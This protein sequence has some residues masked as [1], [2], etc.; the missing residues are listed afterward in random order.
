MIKLKSGVKVSGLKSELLVGM[1]IVASA[2]AEY[3]I[4]CVITSG[5]DST[6]KEHSDH[7]KGYAVDFRVNN[8]PTI[9]IREA[10]EKKVKEAL[11]DDYVFLFETNHFHL[12]YKPIK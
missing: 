6:H 7:Y 8:I 10:I 4:D 3:D 12:G 11:T 1:I 9:E 2:Y 5:N